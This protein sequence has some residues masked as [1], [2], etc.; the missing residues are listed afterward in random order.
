MTCL[1][2]DDGLGFVALTNKDGTPLPEMITR[3]AADRLLGLSPDRLAGEGLSKRAKMQGADR[4]EAKTKK[5]SVRQPG[6]VARPPA[7]RIRRRIRAS[8]LWP[9]QGR[10][11][12]R[13]A[14]R[15]L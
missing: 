15:H 5:N 2:P 12:G 7:R 10:A 6:H 4:K 9:A 14:R 13:Q 1:F 3:H 11:P 8:R